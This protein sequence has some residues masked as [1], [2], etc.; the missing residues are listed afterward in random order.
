MQ[1]VLANQYGIIDYE[2]LG[3][4]AHDTIFPNL[5]RL[6]QTMSAF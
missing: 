3:L 1:D 6:A 2:R 4:A 5:R